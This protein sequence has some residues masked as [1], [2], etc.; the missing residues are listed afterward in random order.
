[1]K[2]IVLVSLLAA[3]TADPST[4]EPAGSATAPNP[5][6]NTGLPREMPCREGV[7]CYSI[8]WH[9]EVN[10]DQ[11]PPAIGAHVA[12]IDAETMQVTLRDRYGSAVA[13]HEILSFGEGCMEVEYDS[14][15]TYVACDC[16]NYVAGNIGYWS[17]G[18]PAYSSPL[19]L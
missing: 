6:V 12:E 19:E 5:D 16:D 7:N 9:C 15:E 4:T 14:D 11:P 13:I 10:C 3:C 17:F 8:T 2:R 1:M 18:G